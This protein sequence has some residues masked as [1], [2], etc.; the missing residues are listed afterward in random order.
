MLKTNSEL[1][2]NLGNFVNR[3]T[4]FTKDNF[5]SCGEFSWACSQ[6]CESELFLKSGFHVIRLGSSMLLFTFKQSIYE[7]DAFLSLK[8]L[9]TLADSF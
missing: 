5:D 7:S 8:I 9:S 4:K 2:A 1:L 6:F 3:A